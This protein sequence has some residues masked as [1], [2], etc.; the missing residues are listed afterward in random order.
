MAPRDNQPSIKL[1]DTPALPDPKYWAHSVSINKSSRLVFTSGITGQTVDDNY[2]ETFSEQVKAS[3]DNLEKAL[4]A[5]GAS[6]R[7][8][9][10]I[11]FLPVDWSLEKKAKEM[12]EPYIM[13]LAET[14]G[15]VNRPLTTTIPVSSLGDPRALFEVEAVATLSGDGVPYTDGSEAVDRSPPPTVVSAVVVGGG[16]SGLQAAFDLQQSGLDCVVLEAKHR[17]GGRSR[18]QKLRTG[19]G[20]IELGA[21]WINK[22]T[23]PKIYELTQK[24]GLEC[25]QQYDAG[26]SVLQTTDGTVRKLKDGKIETIEDDSVLVAFGALMHGIEEGY[27]LFELENP[28]ESPPELDIS[29]ED[30]VKQSCGDNELSNDLGRHLV[31]AL[32]GREVGEVG[33]HFILDYLKSCGGVDAVGGEGELGAQSLKIRQGTSSISTSLADSLRPQSVMLNSPVDAIRQLEDHIIV[34]TSNGTRYKCLKVILAI[35]SNTYEFIQF[36]PPLPHA[37]RAVVSRTMGGVYSKAIVTYKTPWWR[38]IGLSGKFTGFVGPICFSWEI[39]DP[40]LEQ[41][42]LAFFVSGPWA[43]DWGGMNSLAKE[44]AV[45]SHLAVLVGPQNAHLVY[46]PLEFNYLEWH[47]EEF[48]WGAPI[49]S[50]GPGQLGKYGMALHKPFGNIHI[51]GGETAYEWKGFL[52]GALRAGSRAAKEVTDALQAK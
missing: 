46:D 34:Q 39:S 52:E 32:V 36:S 48:I 6:M 13:S 44:D 35:P 3:F 16:F 8:V 49:S 14:Y 43:K 50:M 20:L 11:T 4:G 21:T 9:V 51:A 7:N 45:I 33:I 37:K 5:V 15:W 27:K 40:A 12:F 24:F 26:D 41:Y 17:V 2:P 30:W 38:D 1:A 31:A 19:P 29:V 25:I 10:K 28:L 23:Q 42:S 47:K 22:T 18:S